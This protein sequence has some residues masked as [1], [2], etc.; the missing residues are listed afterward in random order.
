MG[1]K[2]SMSRIAGHRS[3]TSKSIH[4]RCRVRSIRVGLVCNGFFGL[5]T[6]HMGGFSA[7]IGFSV[8]FSVHYWGVIK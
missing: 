8:R 7:R 3:V 2:P 1:T 5:C 4:I 6:R